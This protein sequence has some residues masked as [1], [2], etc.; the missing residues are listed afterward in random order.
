MSNPDA[1]LLLDGR[2]LAEKIRAKYTP[3]LE[4][5]IESGRRPRLVAL[6]V[7]EDPATG[8]YLRGQRRGAEKWGIEYA[9]ETLPASSSED[10]VRKA[11]RSLNADRGVTGLMLALPLPEGIGARGLQHQIDPAKDVEGV[12]PENLGNCFY[13]RYGLLPCTALA[14]M[15]LIE[16]SG[17]DLRGKNAVVVGHSEIVG[18]PVS[19]LLLAKDATVTVCHVYTDD[20]AARTREAD[21]LVVAVGKPDLIR[22]DMVKP[23]AIVVDVGINAIADASR[24][25][26]TRI[27]GDVTYDEV[28]AKAAAITP[29]PGGVGPVTVAVLMRN[30]ILAAEGMPPLDDPNQLPL[31]NQ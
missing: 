1:P 10:A 3:K 30:T 27:V 25:S 8:A 4:A 26:G 24:K 22:G 28:A 20:L 19:V 6:R 29:V 15:A 13:G 23:G 14:C 18:K 9:I 16:A 12:H 11:L 17:V 7:G 2:A 31:F 21:V 5:L